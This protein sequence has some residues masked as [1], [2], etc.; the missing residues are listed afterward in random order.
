M[1][2]ALYHHRIYSLHGD[3]GNI[4][5]DVSAT[6]T[7]I[8]VEAAV[9]ADVTIAVDAQVQ[10]KDGTNSSVMLTIVAID[11][12]AGTITLSA[13][14]G[15]A[16]AAATPTVVRRAPHWAYLWK[17]DETLLTVS[18]ED[19]SHPVQEGS[20]AI[21]DTRSAKEV[22]ILQSDSHLVRPSFDA[23]RLDTAAG[24]TTTVDFSWPYVVTTQWMSGIFETANNGDTYDVLSGPDTPV[25]QLTAATPSGEVVLPVTS[26]VLA[27]T[28]PSMLCKL[29]EGG[30]VNDCGRI[31]KV[32]GT[33]ITVETATTDAFTTSAVV[34]VTALHTQN[35]PVPTNGHEVSVGGQIFKGR[36]LPAGMIIRVVYRNAGPNPSTGIAQVGTLT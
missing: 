8:P 36:D 31:I 25:G 21:I 16:F 9:L 6:D 3:T 15:F 14:V 24:E 34:L 11:A 30:T 22:T 2:T 4:S 10:L 12:G 1:S 18:P 13:P 20:A 19:P 32:N 29:V 17:E 33:T 23:K 7:V 27:N 5:A 26:T 28:R 35:A